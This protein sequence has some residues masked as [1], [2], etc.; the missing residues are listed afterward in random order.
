MNETGVPWNP[1]NFPISAS[2]LSENLPNK[3]MV[4]AVMIGVQ[5]NLVPKTAVSGTAALY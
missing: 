4:T 3:I 2:V 1:G 5:F